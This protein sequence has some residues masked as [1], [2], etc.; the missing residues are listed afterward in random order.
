MKTVTIEQV[1]NGF[2]VKDGDRVQIASCVT[3]YT[4]EPSLAT[5]LKDIFKP[6]EVPAA[7]VVSAAE[8]EPA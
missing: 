5:I 7:P 4:F 2:I 1:E 6:A 8:V 3:S